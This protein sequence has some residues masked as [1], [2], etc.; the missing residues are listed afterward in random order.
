MPTIKLLRSSKRMTCSILR[1]ARS[2]LLLVNMREPLAK[3][4]GVL[5]REHIQNLLAQA[6]NAFSQ[7][8]FVIK[9]YKQMTDGANFVEEV[10]KSARWHDIGKTDPQWQNACLA[11]FAIWQTL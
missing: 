4:S 6:R 9:K 3:P 11:D 1:T 8:S 2:R 7:R 10:E 5:L